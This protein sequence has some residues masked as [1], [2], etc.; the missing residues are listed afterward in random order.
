MIKEPRRL[1]IEER[2][3]DFRSR[4]P[5]IRKTFR[6]RNTAPGA[7]L[8]AGREIEAQMLLRVEWQPRGMEGCLRQFVISCLQIR[9]PRLGTGSCGGKHRPRWIQLHRLDQD[10][11]LKKHEHFVGA[12]VA[13]FGSS[14]LVMCKRKAPTG[15]QTGGVDDEAGDLGNTAR[16]VDLDEVHAGLAASRISAAREIFNTPFTSRRLNDGP[17]HR[18]SALRIFLPEQRAAG[19][20]VKV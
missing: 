9:P 5:S 4:C 17:V 12:D 1:R 20:T 8:R 3:N 11:V 19:A 7:M 18:H 13:G 10:L 14:D 2:T 15:V 16:S 6:T